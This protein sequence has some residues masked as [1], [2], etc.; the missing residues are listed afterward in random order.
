MKGAICTEIL[1]LCI[2]ITE[3]ALVVNL[4]N[5]NFHFPDEEIDSVQVQP[6]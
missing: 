4:L 6:V 1:L 3:A 2:K 5:L